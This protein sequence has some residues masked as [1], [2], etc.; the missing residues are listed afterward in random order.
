MRRF[1]MRLSLGATLALVAA[2][3]AVSHGVT[4]SA[5]T[6]TGKC[7]L[8]TLSPSALGAGSTTT[9][10]FALTNEANPQSL[11][12]ADLTAPTGFVIPPSQPPPVTSAGTATVSSDGTSLDLR[13]L[14]LAPGA[15][16]TVSFEVT[17]PCAM[18]SPTWSLVVKQAN[19]FSGPP[20]NNFVNDPS[21][22]LTTTVSGSCLLSFSA[23]PGNAV[24]STNI[25]SQGFHTSGTPI[26]VEAEDG[27]G[28]PVAGVTVAVSLLPAGG[29][30]TLSGTLSNIT[31]SNGIAT[32]GSSTSPLEINQTGYFELQAS[33]AGFP[34]TQSSGF[35]ITDTAQVCSSNPC[36]TSASGKSGGASVTAIN[37]Q[38]TDIL[39][40]GLGGLSY[41]CDN[42]SQ[43]LYQSVSQPTGTDIWDAS[44]NTI[45][46]LANGQVTLRISKATVRLSPNTGAA[47]FQICYA[48]TEQ[49]TPLFGTAVLTTSVPGSPTLYYGLLPDCGNASPAPVPCVLSRSK[50][51]AGDVLITFDGT[52]DF[53]G[54]G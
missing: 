6:C 9:M 18:P 44:G 4:A 53:W 51:N 31:A 49:F 45:D 39:S 22:A 20:G 37:E 23:E 17:A 35:Q 34:S 27:M 24:L 28:H 2:A 3:G 43:D 1:K 50:N 52:G 11:G 54:Q 41:S 33:A 19:N 8:G 21:S 12:S 15:T 30:A 26:G 40:L 14:N 38:S 32:F 13:S 47:H 25:T 10:S 36:A 48:S 16:A 46:N 29:G 42:S 7:A 5:T